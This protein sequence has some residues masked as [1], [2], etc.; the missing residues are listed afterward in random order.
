LA[1]STA[2]AVMM[3]DLNSL[4]TTDLD[5]LPL[6]P[7]QWEAGRQIALGRGL[8]AC[9][10]FPILGAEGQAL[11][12]IASHRPEV[13][14]PD[15]LQGSL[16]HTVTSLA[17]IALEQRSM[18]ERMRLQAR[19][20]ALTGLPN[21]LALEDRLTQAILEAGQ[22]GSELALLWVDLDGFKTVNDTLGHAV[23]D[24]LLQAITDRM[25]LSIGSGDT[26][27]RIG[28]DEFA[29]VHSLAKGPED[30]A[31]LAERLLES[32]RAPIQIQGR[33]LFVTG[34]IGIALFPQDGQ[35]A[36][37]LQ[38]HADLAM[39]RAKAAGK[40]T[41]ELFTPALTA[42]ALERL[43][44]EHALRHALERAQTAGA[45]ESAQKSGLHHDPTQTLGLELHYQP[46]VD[47]QGQ[48]VAVEA[49]LRWNHPQLG[50]IPPVRFIPVA[51]DCGLIV[52]LGEWVLSHACHQVMRWREQGLTC[53][54][55]AVNVSPIQFSRSDFVQTVQRTLQ[56]SGLEASFLE[57]ELT[58]GIVMQDLEAT[59]KKLF[60]LR[61]MGVSVSIDD[62]GT[63]YSSLK[64]LQRLPIDCLKIDRSFVLEIDHEFGS[65]SLVRTIILLARELGLKVVAEGVETNAQ[66][67]IV[68]ALEC[69]RVQ[70]YLF[71]R[72]VS[73]LN[74]EPF[75]RLN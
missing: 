59:S 47:L 48:I 25:L 5:G 56:T 10:A 14:G 50:P 31:R 22:R 23:G 12:V 70:G 24:G 61:E 63:G 55:V 26:L 35:D 33:A 18:T 29:L 41:F 52:A 43:D 13:G 44:L 17:S 53:V 66:F 37:S 42:V 57:L 28:G 36:L 71:A 38:R 8:R 68:R 6:L 32:F 20:D 2:E 65:R 30:A 62:F 60:S 1:A 46:Q 19:V 16:Y 40:N 15:F 67:D 7:I 58:E 64:Y 3:P 54:P 4:K 45:L 21:R 27:A 74:L 72:P 69:D 73:A 11:G 49:L 39:Y 34:S 75:L 51:E 9:W